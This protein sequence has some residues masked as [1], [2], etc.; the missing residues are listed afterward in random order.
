MNYYIPQHSFL[1]IL[2]THS[3]SKTMT[4]TICKVDAF[5]M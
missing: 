4:E 3:Y 1:L 5:Y 2:C